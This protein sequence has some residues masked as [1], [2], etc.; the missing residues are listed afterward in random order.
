LTDILGLKVKKCQQLTKMDFFEIFLDSGPYVSCHA[1]WITFEIDQDRLTSASANI[2]LDRSRSIHLSL[3]WSLLGLGD[4]S[5]V[6][7]WPR[8]FWVFHRFSR[9]KARTRKWISG[10]SFN[11]I[12]YFDLGGVYWLPGYI[13]SLIGP[14]LNFWILRS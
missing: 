10:Y 8:E 7:V 2:D 9:I 3:E 6:D 14:F 11:W 1:I 13:L 4:R 5:G 12:E